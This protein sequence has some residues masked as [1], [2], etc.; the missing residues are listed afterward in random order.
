MIRFRSFSHFHHN[1]NMGDIKLW[2]TTES[3][4]KKEPHTVIC[5]SHVLVNLVIC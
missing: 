1:F 3:D 5:D 2:K 4:I